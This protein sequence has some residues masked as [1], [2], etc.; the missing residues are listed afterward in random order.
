MLI[1]APALLLPF[2]KI[3]DD[4]RA[5]CPLTA[6]TAPSA[7]SPPPTV[8]SFVDEVERAVLARV[9]GGD[10]PLACQA[11]ENAVEV[12][13]RAACEECGSLEV[14]FNA[15][16]SAGWLLDGELDSA[17]VEARSIAGLGVRASSLSLSSDDVEF[18]VPAPFSTTPPNL[19]RATPLSFSVRL[20][21]DDLNR[22]PLIFGALQELLR[23]LVRSGVSAAIGEA[24]PRDRSGLVVNL[25]RVEPQQ[26]RLI[27]IADAEAT[28]SDGS[29]VKLSGMRVRTRPT[30]SAGA[31]L[32]TLDRPELV[33]SFEGFG[34][35][36]EVGLPFLRA[37]AVPLPSDLCISKLR[38]D[39]GSVLAEGSYTLRPIDYD[40]VLA[41]AAAVAQEVQQARP[42]PDA[43]AVDVDATSDEEPPTDATAPRVRRLP[44]GA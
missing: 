1:V 23:E 12:A 35:R 19:K 39:D 24:L 13:I 25:V 41:T 36:L 28:Q 31:S 5:A 8:A 40:A 42:P 2:P 38:V 32:V 33:S 20:S 15:T 11:A 16:S 21:Q 6:P 17:R 7:P 18:V 34:A 10:K 44:E 14:A 37:A 22:S 4:L 29:V 9:G 27:L 26:N 3:F 43:V 30:A